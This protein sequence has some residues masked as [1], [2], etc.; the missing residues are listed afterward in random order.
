MLLLIDELDELYRQDAKED[1]KLQD[2]LRDLCYFGNSQHGRVATIVCGSSTT[3]ECLITCNVDDDMR[4]EFP[5]MVGAPNLNGTKFATVRVWSST[6][7][8]LDTVAEV[9]GMSRDYRTDLKALGHVRTV[10][11]AA[12]CSTRN[13][14][15]CAKSLKQDDFNDSQVGSNTVD[16]TKKELSTLYF[17]MREAIAKKNKAL[18]DEL[19][20][21]GI[22]TLEKVQSVNWETR[23]KPLTFD[24]VASI[25][26]TMELKGLVQDKHRLLTRVLHLTD[27]GCIWFAEIK[28]CAP[29]TIYPRSLWGIASYRMTKDVRAG[30]V[31]TFVHYLNSAGPR[32]AGA[33]VSRVVSG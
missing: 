1:R 4:R 21:K 16:S 28:D 10:A 30:V 23:F 32:I 2:Y 7:V 20:P 8:D 19:M 27:R 13:L 18:L 6:P 15:R 25:W 11:F 9:L 24:E 26:A 33:V 5:M 22:V 31:E 29:A 14:Q 17:R 12:G 3:M